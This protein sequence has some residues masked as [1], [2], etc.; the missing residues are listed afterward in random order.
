[1]APSVAVLV[2]EA[3]KWIPD[4]VAKAKPLTVNAGGEP[5]TDVGPVISVQARQRIESMIA[6]GVSEGAK[7]GLDGRNPKV[8]GFEKGNFIGPK[9]F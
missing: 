6:K 9:I 8:P 5:G 1:M 4:I 3:N 2:G 7:L